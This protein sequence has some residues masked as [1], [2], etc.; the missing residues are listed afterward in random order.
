MAETKSTAK[1]ATTRK[2]AAKNP[3]DRK[4]RTRA[5]NLMKPEHRELGAAVLAFASEKA[6]ASESFGVTNTVM[7]EIP[8]KRQGMTTILKLDD[9][10][11]MVFTMVVR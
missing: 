6:M 4:V 5:P 9:G 1:K 7:K 11:R 8:G 2:P 3:T 10:T